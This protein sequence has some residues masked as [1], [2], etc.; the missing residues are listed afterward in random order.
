LSGIDLSPD[1]TE[2][3]I[4][5]A[6]R[7]VLR[8]A[9]ALADLTR[10]DPVPGLADRR[11]ARAA[12]LGW[13]GCGLTDALG[14]AGFAMTEEALLFRELGRGLVTP[15]V[16]ATLLAALAVSDTDPDRARAFARGSLRAGIA[17]AAP[18][19]GRLFLIGV[20]PGDDAV[21]I[22]GPHLSLLPAA[23]LAHRTE[24]EC[25]DPT[26][27]LHTVA[28]TATQIGAIVTAP[29]G[30]RARLLLAAQLVGLAEASCAMAVS[31][32]KL[33][34]QFGRPIGAFQAVAHHCADMELRA[35]AA[36]AQLAFAAVAARD[37][38]A[39]APSQI[40]SAVLVAADAAFRNATMTIRVLGGMGYS[41]ES[42]A[43]L[44][45]KRTMVLREAAGGERAIRRALL[46]GPPPT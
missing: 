9:F 37:G 25:V 32:A 35:R 39:D 44:F 4:V 43:H 33:R 23:A 45:L 5:D 21:R 36:D 38:R 27:T 42:G 18:E 17:V 7:A 46:D 13:T 22:D 31:H 12:D 28:G 3:Q 41:S 15:S 14:G 6:T 40:L 19:P 20:G 8:E 10:P 2:T 11:W 1:A 16:M 34:E 26:L 24:V 30:D 29:L